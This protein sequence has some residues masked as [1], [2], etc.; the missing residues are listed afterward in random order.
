MPLKAL[1]VISLLLF[2]GIGCKAQKQQSVIENDDYTLLNKVLEDFKKIHTD[3][4]I[5]LKS[6]NSNEYTV[7]IIEEFK[8]C[9]LSEDKSKCDQLKQN[10][11][12]LENEVKESIFNESEYDL[13]ISQKQSNDWF[14]KKI[15]ASNI[16]HFDGNLRKNNEITVMISK[17]IYTKNKKYALVS[18]GFKGGYIM[19]F[20]KDINNNW[21][22]DKTIF[23]M[24]A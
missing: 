15:T 3:K 21:I 24:I 19:I 5:F 16:L 10:I 12:Y 11:D 17:P 13:L 23:P 2:I 20:K 22:K 14:F 9:R 7:S 6:S 18:V 4:T 1:V 8:N